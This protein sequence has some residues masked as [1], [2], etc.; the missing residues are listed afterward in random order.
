MSQAYRHENSL[1]LKSTT[2][3]EM[4]EFCKRPGK[5]DENGNP[6]YTT[7]QAHKEA[8]DV[9]NILRKY[10]KTGV[11]SHISNIEAKYGDMTG[12]DFREMQAKI[13]DANSRFEQLP[14]EIRNRFKNDPAELLE[15]MENPDNRPEAEKLG[16]IDPNWTEETDGLGEHVKKGMNVRQNPEPDLIEDIPTE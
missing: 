4:R 14:S 2:T 13:A 15:F 11:I 9:N 6:I 5:M 8:V 10:D 7:E 3:P 12:F 1:T 16:L